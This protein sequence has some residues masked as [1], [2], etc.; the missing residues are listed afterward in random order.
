MIRDAYEG[1]GHGELAPWI[2]LLDPK[3]VWRGVDPAI[4]LEEAPT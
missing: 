1:L 2:A 3:V 4:D